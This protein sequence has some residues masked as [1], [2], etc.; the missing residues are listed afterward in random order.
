MIS[1]GGYQSPDTAY[2]Y[3][4]VYMNTTRPN[5]V[6]Y[7]CSIVWNMQVSAR[8]DRKVRDSLSRWCLGTPKCNSESQ[9]YTIALYPHVG[10]N[11]STTG[12]PPY[13]RAI[14]SYLVQSRS[15]LLLWNNRNKSNAPSTVVPRLQQIYE[16]FFVSLFT[17]FRWN[18]D[19]KYH[20]FVP[21]AREISLDWKFS[22]KE[23][24]EESFLYLFVIIDQSHHVLPRLFE[25]ILLHALPYVMMKESSF[26]VHQ[27]VLPGE[28]RP[29]V[30][31]SCVVA[32]HHHCPVR[33]CQ[34]TTRDGRGWLIINTYLRMHLFLFFLFSNKLL[35]LFRIKFCLHGESFIFIT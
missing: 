5:F 7:A 13:L 34:I 24:W 35:K 4:V 1:P 15:L 18:K 16:K 3:H 10:A 17:T 30:S 9:Y 29:S 27:V 33:F 14:L 32:D 25:K 6:I 22:S 31:H 8:T 28:H 20:L 26:L 21:H 19:R 23:S 2:H 12:C 11:E